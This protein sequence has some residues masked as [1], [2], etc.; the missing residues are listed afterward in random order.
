MSGPSLPDFDSCPWPPNPGK[1]GGVLNS[2]HRLVI[3]LKMPGG[4]VRDPLEASRS[5]YVQ[6]SISSAR[7]TEAI[8]KAEG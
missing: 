7:L 3:L 6:T 2:L 8:K 5:R 1:E 4:S